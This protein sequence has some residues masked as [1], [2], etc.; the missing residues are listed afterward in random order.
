MQ[1]LLARNIPL[2]GLPKN[3]IPSVPDLGFALQTA[4]L[5]QQLG[6]GSPVVLE[7]VMRK[8]VVQQWTALC[9]DAGASSSRSNASA[10][11]A[12]FTATGS[13]GGTAPA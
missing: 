9:Q 11:T 6:L 10:P 7:C 1:T 2:D 4:I 13:S 5:T 3:E 12:I 8:I